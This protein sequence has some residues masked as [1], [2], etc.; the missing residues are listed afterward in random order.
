V[1]GFAH[2][3]GAVEVARDKMAKEEVEGVAM[4]R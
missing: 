4:A 3:H 1:Q 2:A